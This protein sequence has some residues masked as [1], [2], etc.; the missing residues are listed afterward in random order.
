[1]T[2][3]R[4]TEIG[5]ALAD[6]KENEVIA[7]VNRAIEAGRPPL[8]IIDELSQGM[9]AVGALY[10]AGEYFLAELLFSGEIFKGAMSRL[11]PIIA[12]AGGGRQWRGT[13]VMGTV[14]GD[15]HDLGKNIVTMLLQC[16]GFEVIDLGVD[17]PPER[18]LAALEGS[19]APL[20][21]LSGLITTAFGSMKETVEAIRRAG[22][23]DA[24]RIMIGGGPTSEEVRVHV[25]ADFYGP[26]AAS[27]VEIAGR[28]IGGAAEQAIP[29]R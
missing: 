3:P 20:V 18:F 11:E 12:S 10:K 15:I 25:G 8:G 19:R 27:A 14:K 22:M 29:V 6:L 1:M 13:V 21:G 4:L 17:V 28:V 2:E 5:R 9:E 7:L 16:A 24:V 26:D 23:R